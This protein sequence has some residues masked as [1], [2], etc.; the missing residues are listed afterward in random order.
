M[1]L[2]RLY[3]LEV[4]LTI[5]LTLARRSLISLEDKD[6]EL[7]NKVVSLSIEPGVKGKEKFKIQS[8]RDL[9]AK[10]AFLSVDNIWSTWYPNEYTLV[11]MRPHIENCKIVVNTY[12]SVELGLTIS[13]D[14]NG[15]LFPIPY[16]TLWYSTT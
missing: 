3:Y 11:F 14:H 5:Q 10:L 4:L 2:Y 9:E 6:D 1:E 16:V 12:I 8:L 13:S 15:K 7:L